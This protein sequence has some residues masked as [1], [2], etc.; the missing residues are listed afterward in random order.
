MM[1]PGDRWLAYPFYSSI[2]AIIH[3]APVKLSLSNDFFCFSVFPSKRGNKS[4]GLTKKSQKA[5]F[6]LFT[7]PV[8]RIFLGNTDFLVSPNPDK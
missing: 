8:D 2:R 4:L 1:T 6:T 5:N 3:V 7:E